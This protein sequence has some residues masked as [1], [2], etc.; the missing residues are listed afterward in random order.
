MTY[1]AVTLCF[2][3]REVAGTPQVLLGTKKTG[4]GMGKIVGLGGHVEPGETDEE[5]ACREVQEEAAVVVLETDLRDAGVVVF[6][7]PARPEWNM[8]TRLFVAERWDGEPTESV[9]IAP[10]WFDVG[11]LPVERMWQDAAH[12]LPMALDGFLL[13]LTVVLNDDNETVR[14][15]LDFSTR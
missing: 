7:F 12:W 5:A 8:S 10:E 2:L 15:V 3:T 13:R 6:D 4:F 9:E 14:E 11:S 1:T